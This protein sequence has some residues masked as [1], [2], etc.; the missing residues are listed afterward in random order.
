MGRGFREMKAYLA[1]K[2]H[3]DNANRPLIEALSHALARGGYETV[4]VVRD[5][6]R[7][8][9]VHLPP[10]E[11][12]RAS[13]AALDTCDLVVVELTEK[14]VGIGIEAGYAWARGIP[15]LTLAQRGADVSTTLQG[16][17][18]AV[19]WY[20]GVAALDAAVSGALSE[21]RA[22]SLLSSSFEKVG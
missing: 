14:G 9:E 20:D 16:I 12:M 4:C 19:V 5:V 10:E 7:W 17:S 3:P 18:R 2:Y 6:E 13:F 8:G 22:R 1:I 15:I 21:Y 11:L